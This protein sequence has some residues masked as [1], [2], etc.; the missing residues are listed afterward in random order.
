MFE[1]P[2]VVKSLEELKANIEG[3]VVCPGDADYD[4]ARMS[5]N[6]SYDQ[7]P[8]VI[9]VAANAGDVANAV[10]YARSAGLGVAVMATGHGVI[11]NA[12]DAMLIVTAG[13]TAVRVDTETETAWV[14][15]GAKWGAV[16]EKAQEVGL[17]PLLGSSPDVGAVGYTLGGGMGWLVRKYGMS[18]DSVL[19]FDVITADG[20]MLRVSELENSD[21]FWG[22]RGGGGGFAIVTAMCIRLYPV[23]TVYGGN[24]MYPEAQAKEVFQFYREWIQW[25]PAEW[26]T[27]ISIMNFPP[28]PDVPEPLRGQSVIIIKGC[29]CGDAGAGRMMLQA[30][31]DWMPP[32]LNTF[33]DMPF[34]E[35]ATIS[36]DPLDPMPAISSGGWPT[37]MTRRLHC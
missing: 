13:M 35:V 32:M 34:S 16:L 37:W 8:A 19:Y 5:W 28:I 22:M 29:Y 20:R 21:L 1:T 30:W 24:L 15:A 18:V 12:D 14:E 36:A 31:L 3:A 33:R 11:L 2:Y 6:L 17:A 26:T 4:S 10:L 9:V 27:S 25:L 23:T 7:Y